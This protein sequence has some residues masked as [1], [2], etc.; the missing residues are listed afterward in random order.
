MNMRMSGKNF[1]NTNT[2]TSNQNAHSS[3]TYYPKHLELLPN[4]LYYVFI[5]SLVQKGLKAVQ[6]D[7]TIFKDKLNTSKEMKQMEK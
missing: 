6:K 2:V 3:I 4:P 7:S 1:H 5:L